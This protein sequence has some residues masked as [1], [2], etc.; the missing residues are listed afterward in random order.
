MKRKIVVRG[1][2]VVIPEE[3]FIDLFT[4]IDDLL[5]MLLEKIEQLVV[6]TPTPTEPI[7]EEVL[8]RIERLLFAQFITDMDRLFSFLQ[9]MGKATTIKFRWNTGLLAAG[10]SAEVT[11]NIPVD[12]VDVAE[13]LEW[14]LSEYYI[15]KIEWYRDGDLIWDEDET[16]DGK[17]QWTWFEAE[18][19]DSCIIRTTNGSAAVASN[20]AI[21]RGKCCFIDKRYYST[22]IDSITTLVEDT[23]E[24]EMQV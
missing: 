2:E 17:L 22:I 6:P 20:R 13:E 23:I 15:M 9:K 18:A 3:R 1:N 19:F 5:V 4:R 14:H 16:V 10:E 21:W 11:Y 7:S 12:Y 24:E 8:E